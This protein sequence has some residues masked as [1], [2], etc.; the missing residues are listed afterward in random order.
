MLRLFS[1]LLATN[2]RALFQNLANES[3]ANDELLCKATT[4]AAKMVF[5]AK[6]CNIFTAGKRAL[7]NMANKYNCL[8]K[9]I[10]K[11]IQRL[12]QKRDKERRSN[13]YV[14]LSQQNIER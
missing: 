11:E 14:I 5:I 4:N 9:V 3:K 6:D 12:I 2:H 8:N 1:R 13:Q 7:E 10:D